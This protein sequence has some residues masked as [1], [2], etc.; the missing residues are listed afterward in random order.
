V[1]RLTLSSR[2]GGRR[3]GVN[4]PAQ[5]ILLAP[6]FQIS[7]GKEWERGERG[8]RVNYSIKMHSFFLLFK[9]RCKTLL[10]KFYFIPSPSLP[11]LSYG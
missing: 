9:M 2:R 1:K 4:G 8:E 5:T 10:L 11:S 6:K 7:E 3:R